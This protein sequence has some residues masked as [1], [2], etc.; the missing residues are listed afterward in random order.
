[1]P[2]PSINSASAFIQNARKEVFPTLF[3]QLSF[4]NLIPR[5]RLGRL[6]P[7]STWLPTAGIMKRRCQKHQE[8]VLCPTSSQGPQGLCNWERQ[9][10]KAMAQVFSTYVV[11]QRTP[12]SGHRELISTLTMLQAMQALASMFPPL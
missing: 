3:T 10:R 4:L 5:L 7:E 11:V 8:G 9:K 6:C 12:A 1:M 2:F